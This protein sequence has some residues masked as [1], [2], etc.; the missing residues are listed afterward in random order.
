MDSSH[1][2]YGVLV[3]CLF[4][5]VGAPA[6]PGPRPHYCMALAPELP[7]KGR[8]FIA[9]AYGT[10]KLD[11]DLLEEHQGMILRVSSEFIK[12]EK[13]PQPTGYFVMD[14]VAVIPYEKEW[15]L[16][17]SARFDFVTV[18]QSR[19]SAAHGRLY[20]NLLFTRP[21]SNAAA[22]RAVT[23]LIQTGAIG[24]IGAAKLR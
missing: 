11:D 6:K 19:K 9:V 2:D 22:K 14:H 10:S 3:K 20:E 18:E 16:P 15:V 4:P 7:F 17:F 8:K 23:R 5:Y 21:F 13:P 1:I 24:L 12:G